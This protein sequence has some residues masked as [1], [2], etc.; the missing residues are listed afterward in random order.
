MLAVVLSCVAKVKDI[1]N[2]VDERDSYERYDR[3]E[4]VA[5]DEG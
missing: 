1:T 2:T 5:L 4:F 3:G